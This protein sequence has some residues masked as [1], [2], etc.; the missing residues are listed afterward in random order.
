[1]QFFSLYI[2]YS[3]KKTECQNFGHLKTIFYESEGN[4][5]PKAEVSFCSVTKIKSGN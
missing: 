2:K 5:R 3:D 4:I 1:M